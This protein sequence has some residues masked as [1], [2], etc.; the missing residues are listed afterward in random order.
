MTHK[1]FGKK[2]KCLRNGIL[3]LAPDEPSVLF[4]SGQR[5]THYAGC[6]DSKMKARLLLGFG[7]T[8]KNNLLFPS[9]VITRVYEAAR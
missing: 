9:R 8:N 6:L 1:D 7:E 4:G 5:W 3:G 2:L